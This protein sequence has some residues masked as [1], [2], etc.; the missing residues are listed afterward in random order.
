MKPVLLPEEYSPRLLVGVAE[1]AAGAYIEQVARERAAPVTVILARAA[2]QLDGLAEDILFFHELAI[3]SEPRWEVL[4]YPELPEA[5]ADAGL[6][7]RQCDRLAVLAALAE[8]RGKND[9][10][11]VI[12][13][14]LAAVL[15]P[16]PKPDALAAREVRLQAGARVNFAELAQKLGTTLGYDSEALCETP[17][18]F[19]VRGGLL[20]VYPYNADAPAR[21]DFFGDELESIRRF[22]P[23]TQLTSGALTEL[24]IAPAPRALGVETPAGLLN[25]LPTV[26]H[27]IAHEPAPQALEQTDLFAVP[28]KHH[29]PIPTLQTVLTARDD[30]DDTW[31][32][33]AELDEAGG[34]FPVETKRSLADSEST[35]MHRPLA[36]VP[37]L[38][39]TRLESDQAAQRDFLRM[40]AKW[41]KEGTTV[42][43]VTRA[44]S[45]AGRLREILAED[46]ALRGFSPLI[47]TGNLAAGFRA[48][49]AA[50]ELVWPALGK[51]RSIAVVAEGEIFGRHRQ[52]ISTFR[53]RRLPQRHRVDQ[54]L[55]FSEIAEGDY[56]VHVAQGVCRFRGVRKLE[57]KGRIEEVISL[58]FADNVELHLPLHESHLLSRYVG[59]AKI[60]PKLGKVG[61]RQ[62]EK[63]RH[64]AERAT[65]DF[66][67]ELL[68]LQA[69]ARWRFNHAQVARAD[70][71]EVQ[72][73]RNGR[74]AH[75]QHMHVRPQMLELFLMPHAKTMLLVNDDESEILEMHIRAEQPVRA[76]DDVEPAI[77][78]LRQHLFLLLGGTK[79]T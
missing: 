36:S 14:T 15:Q 76:D 33:L 50:A 68:R 58:E 57:T 34:P 70:K 25:Y 43:I 38:G 12:I 11:L 28:E 65:L 40:L 72:R 69:V 2:R 41:A 75:R 61:G 71:R 16:A 51:N 19:A 39:R 27:W 1:P 10:P 73:A 66:A 67:A 52:R 22:D 17:G 8:R 18:Q 64:E 31:T 9:A 30:N 3:G 47:K 23:T 44:D 74:G 5:G 29:A 6:F 42:V 77:A 37:V 49:A 7:E 21:L 45:E 59:L 4:L 56:L 55:D 35:L 32:G 24:V 48:R 62:W 20:D 26:V 78:Q 60:A 13:T 53:V 54:L 79:T 46:A 63:T